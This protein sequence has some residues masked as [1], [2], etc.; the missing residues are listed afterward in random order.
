[1]HSASTGKVIDA[2]GTRARSVICWR[3]AEPA[4]QRHTSSVG[5]NVGPICARWR[6]AT[7]PGTPRSD[8]PT[9]GSTTGVCRGWSARRP[10]AIARSSAAAR[11]VRD[12]RP[13]KRRTGPTPT[14]R[15]SAPS[16]RRSPSGPGHA[17]GDQVRVHPNYCNPGVQRLFHQHPWLVSF[18]TRV[19]ASPA[20]TR[21]PGQE[22]VRIAWNTAS[23]C[24]SRAT[25]WDCSSQSIRTPNARG[26]RKNDGS[27]PRRRAW[28]PREPP[29]PP[30]LSA[31]P[32]LPK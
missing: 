22:S 19:S 26:G 17:S 8:P 32:S 20:P 13:Q 11:P 29:A 2:V 21:R 27:T 4:H 5:R 12:Q 30:P 6:S 9:T 25:K 28:R 10:C 31:G 14:G 3:H 23:S 15:R 7:R 1:M 24:Q 18:A 16:P